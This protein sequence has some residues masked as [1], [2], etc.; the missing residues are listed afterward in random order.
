MPEKLLK[1]LEAAHRAHP[2]VDTLAAIADALASA[3][4]PAQAL[5]WAD[6]Q[7][8]SQPSLLGL[9]KLL[10]LRQAVA[11]EAEQLTLPSTLNLCAPTAPVPDS[12]HD[13]TVQ[14]RV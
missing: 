9:E 1:A 11:A 7:L 12:G 8:R 6:E 5:R 4:G 10:G 2:G 14:L 3:Q 13:P